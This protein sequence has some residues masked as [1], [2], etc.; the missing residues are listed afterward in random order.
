[1]IYFSFDDFF[2]LVF[3]FSEY[4]LFVVGTDKKWNEVDVLVNDNMYRPMNNTKF[5]LS[6]LIL[7]CTWLCQLQCVECNPI[8]PST[9]H[10]PYIIMFEKLLDFFLERLLICWSVQLLSQLHT[11]QLQ[12]GPHVFTFGFTTWQM[13]HGSQVKSVLGFIDLVWNWVQSIF[14]NILHKPLQP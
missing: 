8:E 3:I 12:S 6:L 1:M 7:F 5:N 10:H 4:P 13:N 9:E 11:D 14:Q 2:I